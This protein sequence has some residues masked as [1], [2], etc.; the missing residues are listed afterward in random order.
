M[1]NAKSLSK[2]ADIYEFWA[3]AIEAGAD[4]ILAAQYEIQEDQ[5]ERASELMDDAT[6]LKKR[7]AELRK[8]D[9][10]MIQDGYTVPQDPNLGCDGPQAFLRS[11]RIR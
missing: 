7:A 9:N 1:Q 4:E 8:I 10:G 11:R 3:T 6:S 2:L 5:F